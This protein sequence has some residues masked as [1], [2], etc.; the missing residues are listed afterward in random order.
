MNTMI[1][2][3]IRN[4][5]LESIYH[6][7]ETS[8]GVV[9]SK[10]LS[11]LQATGE[12]IDA[13]V[14]FVAAQMVR[15]PKF[16]SYWRTTGCN[17]RETQ[18]AVID[19]PAIRT[20]LESAVQNIDAN[21]QQMLSLLA[22]PKVLGLLGGMRAQLFKAPDA[23]AFITSDAPCCV[24]DYKDA[25]RSPLDS[26]FGSTSNVLM[27]LSPDVVVLF[28]KSEAPHEMTHILPGHAFVEHAN[29]IIW[30][31]AVTTV[32]LPSHF[33]H[34]KWLR[35]SPSKSGTEYVVM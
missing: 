21:L 5:L 24:I 12:D 20:A 28:D 31:G 14:H 32:I 7:I 18:L 11:G 27:P 25:A 3:G 35:M 16:R 2:D 30:A 13:I 17:E 23:R 33:I 6:A 9:R 26:L 22:F 4:L 34:E 10:I 15:T 8:F 29:A 1:K 19:D